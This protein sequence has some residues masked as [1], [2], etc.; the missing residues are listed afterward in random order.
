MN[1][2]STA[3]RIAGKLRTRLTGPRTATVTRLFMRFK[4]K[5]RLS[6]SL[7]A[8]RQHVIPRWTTYEQAFA[9][10]S[11][12]TQ[13]PDGYEDEDD[14]FDDID[15]KVAENGEEEDEAAAGEGDFAADDEYGINL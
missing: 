3:G 5:L 1:L 8:G 4:R 14:G 6:K 9:A 11:L 10:L 2:F 15:E 13:A 12:A 7:S